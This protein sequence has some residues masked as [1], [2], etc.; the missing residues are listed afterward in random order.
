MYQQDDYQ[1]AVAWM[2][3]G[4]VKVAPLTTGHFSFDSYADAYQYI[5]KNSGGCLKVMID[6]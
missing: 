2:A 4:Q 1:Q 6:F 5:D 3:A